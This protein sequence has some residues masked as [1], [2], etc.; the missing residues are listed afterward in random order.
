MSPYSPAGV[1]VIGTAGHTSTDVRDPHG[2]DGRRSPPDGTRRPVM[3][4]QHTSGSSCT[5][6]RRRDR[7]RPRGLPDSGTSHMA[8]DP[9]SP[10][11]RPAP[12]RVALERRGSL[13]YAELLAP[14]PVPGRGRV[15]IACRRAWTSRSRCT[16]ACWPARRP[17]PV[18]PRLA[19]RE[20]AA[21]V[22][23]AKVLDG[24]FPV[25][26]AS[27]RPARTLALVVH[28]SGTTGAPRA[29]RADARRTSRPTR[30]ARRPRSGSTPTSAGCARCRCRTSAG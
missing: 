15:P 14:R 29:G 5:A 17:M 4:H 8:I 13:T 23:G 21:L 20:R 3:C 6:S 22:R 11:G 7:R 12:D 24:P 27:P 10:R 2:S 9:G 26:P 30:W 28:T 19:A 16:P 1:Q 25:R 18:D